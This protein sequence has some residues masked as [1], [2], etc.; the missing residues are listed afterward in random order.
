MTN[1]RKAILDYL[2]STNSHPAAITIYKAV[3]DKLPQI[4]FATVYRT[5]NFLK[6]QGM[7]LEI[8]AGQG[9]IRFDGNPTNHY[10]FICSSCKEV[11]DIDATVIEDIEQKLGKYVRGKVIEHRL[12]LIG[13]C[14]DCLS[15]AGAD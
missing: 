15:K 9:Y 7:L 11:V 1:Q 10:H 14:A 8:D 6:E 2:K 5:L 13:I 3:K 4:S 12:N